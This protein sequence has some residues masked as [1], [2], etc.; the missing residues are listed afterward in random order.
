RNAVGQFKRGR[1]GNAKGRPRGSENRKKII[2]RIMREMHVVPEYGK[3]RRRST[4]D[5]ILISLRNRAAE[6]D[7]RAFQA[8][9]D[10]LERFEPR[11]PS[12]EVG[13]LLIPEPPF[14]KHELRKRLEEQQRAMMEDVNWLERLAATTGQTR[15]KRR[16]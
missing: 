1:S 9:H 13:Y 5:L 6:G 8:L 2:T 11:P 14:P 12:Q 10:W 15:A 3:R 4:L 16:F 7:V